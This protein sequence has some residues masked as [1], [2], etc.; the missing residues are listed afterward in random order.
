MGISKDRAKYKKLLIAAS[1]IED[2]KTRS[3]GQKNWISDEENLAEDI[4]DGLS[5][6]DSFIRI[7]E[8]KKKKGN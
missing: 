4:N 1:I 8:D 7:P 6:T 2:M 3:I 5:D